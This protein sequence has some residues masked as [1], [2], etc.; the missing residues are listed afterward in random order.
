MIIFNEYRQAFA[1][2]NL[3]VDTS[4][5]E[6]YKDTDNIKLPGSRSHFF[7]KYNADFSDDDYFSDLEINIQRVSNPTYLEVHDINTELVDSS[8]NILNSNI[9]YEYQDDTNYLGL[10]ASVFE[11][12]KKQ[13][14]QNMNIF[15]QVCHLKE[16]YIMTKNLV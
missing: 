3:I 15:Y 12:L 1:N 10:S 14:D 8:N 9:N 6:G 13:I 16:I 4:Y 5:T 11:D 2:S 7:I